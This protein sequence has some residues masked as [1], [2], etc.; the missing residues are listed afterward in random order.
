MYIVHIC[1]L[2]VFDI[3]VYVY[4]VLRVCAYM[5]TVL[6]P[7]KAETKAGR[8]L[9]VPGQPGLYLHSETLSNKKKKT[10][11]RSLLHAC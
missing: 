2:N 3:S 10:N 6:F 9:C 8:S 7:C 5:Y 1:V 11:N 4:I